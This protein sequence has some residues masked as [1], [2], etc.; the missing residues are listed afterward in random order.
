MERQD[1][2]SSPT[3]SIL[4]SQLISDSGLLRD[5]QEMAQRI[6]HDVSDQKNAVPRP[7]FFQEMPDGIFLRN[8][9]II[10]EG[11]GQH[12]VDFLWHG[13]VKTAKTR[14]HVGY[15]N[16]QFHRGKRDGNRGIDVADHYHHVG[17]P[18]EK[19]RLDPL[20]DF[21]GLRRV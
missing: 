20:Q 7:A 15:A 3:S 19:N 16:A 11:I 4:Q 17:L 10:R 8:E 13:A 1:A 2:E 12:A 18:F 9:Q 6:D 21:R 14:L 5:R